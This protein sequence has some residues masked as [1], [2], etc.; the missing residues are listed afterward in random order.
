MYVSHWTTTPDDQADA[1]T[2]PDGARD[3]DGGMARPFRALLWLCLG[4][5]LL[6]VLCEIISPVQSAVLR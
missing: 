1:G 5:L 4:T 6:I 3:D 2:C